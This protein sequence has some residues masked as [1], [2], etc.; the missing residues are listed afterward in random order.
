[1]DDGLVHLNEL[2]FCVEV[3]VVANASE[4]HDPVFAIASGNVSAPCLDISFHGDLL[5][6]IVGDVIEVDG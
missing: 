2:H 1:M 5:P 6:D 4:E 3:L